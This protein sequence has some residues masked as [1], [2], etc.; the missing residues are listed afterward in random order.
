V[1]T[2]RLARNAK[3]GNR[4]RGFAYVTF[5]S[6]A[7]LKQALSYNGKNLGGRAVKVD[8]SDASILFLNS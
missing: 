7:G 4:S 1:D 3:E 5:L 8:V 2:I 6:Q